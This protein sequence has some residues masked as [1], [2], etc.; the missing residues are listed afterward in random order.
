MPGDKLWL[1]SFYT[2]NFVR[3]EMWDFRT[4][5]PFW[6]IIRWTNW[7]PWKIMRFFFLTISSDCILFFF[8]LF[9]WIIVFFRKVGIHSYFWYIEKNEEFLGC[10]PSSTLILLPAFQTW[11]TDSHFTSA[12]NVFIKCRNPKN[13]SV[14]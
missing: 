7:I 14:L 3:R 13:G 9:T 8:F 5:N 4:M 11:H 6:T 2:F 10:V 1:K 12:L